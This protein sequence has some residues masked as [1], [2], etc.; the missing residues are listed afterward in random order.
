MSLILTLV[1]GLFLA[2]ANGANDNFKG[3]ATL[4]GSGTTSYKKAL[5]WATLTT[6]LGSLTA[7]FL[8]KG[9]I[10]A[11]SGKGLVP[12]HILELKSF[13]LAVGLAAA[14]TVMLATR[15][16]F[17]VS[18][19][20]SLVG[21]LIGAGFVAMG[22]GI[23]LNQA[24]GTFFLP[25]LI[26]PLFAAF[27]VILLHPLVS[28]AGRFLNITKENCL[29]V[30][31]RVLRV[32]PRGISM[33]EAIMTV[34][35]GIEITVGT[36]AQCMERYQGRVLGIDVGS[37]LDALHYLSAGVVSFARGL[38]DTP[39]IVAVLLVGGYFNPPL[40]MVFVGFF[41]GVGGILHS[42][43]VAEKMSHN[44]TKMNHAEG[45]LANLITSFLVIFAS[46]LGMPV[47]TTHVSCGALFGIGA[48]TSKANLKTINSIIASWLITLPLAMILSGVFF[49]L[50][51]EV[52]A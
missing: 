51:R 44:I 25:L 38:N 30:G 34:P 35:S 2:Y 31:S 32:V 28:K 19:T 52:M 17:P 6:L 7:V 40:A 47:S 20:H 24:M 1:C 13:P 21:S 26:S 27:G 18:T 45:L 3:V 39:K 8:A 9:L 10:I 29:C 22:T 49:L 33:E 15:F 37:L 16:G 4:Y 46:R 11:F 5:A 14:T 12:N 36:K 23:N 50:L 42:R 43:K 48:V 41:I